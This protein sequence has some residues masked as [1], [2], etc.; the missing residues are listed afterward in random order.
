MPMQ[1]GTTTPISSRFLIFALVG[2]GAM[3]TP[4]APAAGQAANVGSRPTW[5]RSAPVFESSIDPAC[6]DC[7]VEHDDRTLTL[8]VRNYGGRGGPTA[9]ATVGCEPPPEHFE[10]GQRFVVKAR[11]IA[12]RDVEPG[13]MWADYYMMEPSFLDGSA[14]EPSTPPTNG[15]LGTQPWQRTSIE[16]V[17]Y[18][19]HFTSYSP[20]EKK[21]FLPPADHPP[22]IELSLKGFGSWVKLTWRYAPSGAQAGPARPPR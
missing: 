17:R 7:L 21:W 10:L 2:L 8:V 5:I 18:F 9:K 20:S 22:T 6:P 11:L 15:N 12:P 1:G 14:L 3:T 4:L 16:C 19:G 13:S